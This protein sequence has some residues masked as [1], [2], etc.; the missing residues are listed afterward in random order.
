[1][2]SWAVLTSG[3]GKFSCCI[4]VESVEVFSVAFRV[5][6]LYIPASHVHPVV[7][8]AYAFSSIGRFGVFGVVVGNCL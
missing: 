8:F 5:A 4:V 1:L 2:F 3:C 6:I 7:M